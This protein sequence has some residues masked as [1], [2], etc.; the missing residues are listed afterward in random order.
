MFILIPWDINCLIMLNL[1]ILGTQRSGTTLLSRILTAHPKVFIQNEIS[2]EKVFLNNISKIKIIE[3][4]NS[5][6][7]LRHG[8]KIHDLW[9]KQN[10]NFFVLKDPELTYHIRAL[11]QFIPDS[12]FII[13]IR[14]GHA[15]V[16]SYKENKWGLGTN[17]YT[18][19]L[20]WK[21]EVQLQK[22]F[23]KE[24][25]DSFLLIKFEDLITDLEKTLRKICVHLS[26]V[27]DAE[28]LNYN[29]ATAQFNTNQS[30]INTNQQPDKKIAQKWKSKLS[31][32][33][34][35]IIESV[36]MDELLD[37]CYPLIGNIISLR[38]Y[39]KLYY[40][41]HQLILGEIQIQYRLK[42]PMLKHF[43]KFTS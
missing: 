11:K 35:N 39:Q 24:F 6:I 22:S 10:K 19:A 30:N 29:L 21:K 18:G 25:P 15:V 26:I 16:N 9:L 38:K 34:I 37:N 41:L 1:F 36:A 12:K 14:D 23:M 20:R 3:N 7:Q 27:F 32:H 8:H 17:V 43:L 2:V 31:D 40:N 42:M 13:I 28:M 5:Q 4:I 33:E